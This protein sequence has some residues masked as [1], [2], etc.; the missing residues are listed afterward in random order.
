VSCDSGVPFSVTPAIATVI[1]SGGQSRGS[2]SSVADSPHGYARTTVLVGRHA[3]RLGNVIST[4]A[5]HRPSLS[6]WPVQRRRRRFD[7]DGP[8]RILKRDLIAEQTRETENDQRTVVEARAVQQ[9]QSPGLDWPGNEELV[10]VLI[11]V[12]PPNDNQITRSQVCQPLSAFGNTDL[13]LIRSS[14]V[15]RVPIECHHI[16]ILLRHGRRKRIEFAPALVNVGRREDLNGAD[17]GPHAPAPVLIGD[18]IR[19]AMGIILGGHGLGRNSGL[20]LHWRGL[21]P[22]SRKDA[23]F[24]S[25]SAASTQA[26]VL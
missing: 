25:A 6:S 22:G 7:N 2:G 19:S 5:K 24:F 21:A 18:P 4:T 3:V 15:E 10:P 26:I 14:H 13:M 16:R 9:S 12:I 8:N 23:G 20:S 1:P 17:F 11:F